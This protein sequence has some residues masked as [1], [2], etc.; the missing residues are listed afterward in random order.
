MASEE[1]IG[2]DMRAGTIAATGRDL[3]IAI[4]GAALFLVQAPDGAEA[5][6]GLLYTSDAADELPRVDRVG[7]SAPSNN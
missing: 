4:E 3:D 6:T 1:V 5:Y 2:A 7:C